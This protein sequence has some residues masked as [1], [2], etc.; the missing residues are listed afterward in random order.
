MGKKITFCTYDAPSFHSVNTWLK[1]LLPE[2]SNHDFSIEALVFF[3]GELSDC[4]TYQFFINLG[5]NVHAFPFKSLA[6]EKIRW[7]LKTLSANPPDIFVPNMLVHALFAAH[8]IKKA[9]IPTIGLI[10]SDDK[11][12]NGIISEFVNGEEDYKLTC[13]VSCSK[14]LH[15]K[16]TAKQTSNILFKCIPYGVPIV[17]IHKAD[18][19]KPELKLIYTGRLVEKQ[20]RISDV[21]RAMCR[22][23]NQ[24]DGVEGII[25]GNGDESKVLNLIKKHSTN[26]KVKFGGSISNKEIFN[27]LSDAHVFV[28]LSDYEGLPQSLLEA[29]ACGLVPVCSDIKSGIPELITN[30]ETGIIVKNRNH[31]FVEAVQRLK[32]DQALCEKIS[33]NVKQKAFGYSM[34]VC[35]NAWINLLNELQSKTT[36]I[37]KIEIPSTIEL[38]KPHP[39]LKMEDFRKPSRPDKFMSTLRTTK[40]FYYIK[41]LTSLR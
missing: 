8:W 28:L 7:I 19:N 37:G 9:G 39:F 38:P 21:V 16:A 14:Y 24:I 35:T 10:H 36:P 31:E 1:T 17:N 32:N 25:Y 4:E 2:L 34:E 27:A 33:E 11:F 41:K 3:E 12:Y 29:M 18:F 26:N 20:K 40:I 15:K 6:E 23:S 13:V 22:A 5:Y 30:N